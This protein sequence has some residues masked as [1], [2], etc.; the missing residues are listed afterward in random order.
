[1]VACANLGGTP[2]G[3]RRLAAVE[4]LDLEQDSSLRHH[5]FYYSNNYKLLRQQF[6]RDGPT[7]DGA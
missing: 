4:L 7:F 3:P 5:K 6:Y 2:H 1:M